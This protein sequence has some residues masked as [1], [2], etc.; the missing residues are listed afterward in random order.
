MNELKLF[1][2]DYKTGKNPL[3]NVLK[4]YACYD[5]QLGYVQ[6]VNY[7]VALLLVQIGDEERAFWCLV[8][9]MYRKNWRMVYDNNT[10]KLMS[11][12]QVVRQKLQ[13]EDPQLLD[14]LESEDLSMAAA[15]SPVFIT[16]FIY[17]TP[18]DIATRIFEYFLLDGERSL[19]KFLFRML[20]YKR[21][22]ILSLSEGQLQ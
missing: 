12:L 14:H 11:L 18:L 2:Q 21:E 22:K 15:F 1:T 13:K 10:P 17:C 20:Y 19:L 8:S 6:G 4:A 16:L 7:I 9:L 5:N 3:F